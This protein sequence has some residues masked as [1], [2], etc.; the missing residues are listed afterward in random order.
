MVVLEGKPLQSQPWAEI[1]PVGPILVLTVPQVNSEIDKRKRDGRLW[2]RARE[3]NKL[4]EPAAL[5]VKPVQIVAGPPAVDIGI[6]KTSKVDW[7][8]LD[9][10]DPDDQDAKVVAQILHSVDVPADKRVFLSQDINPIT[11]ASRHGVSVRKLLDHWL[12][13]PEPSPG[14]KEAAKLKERLNILE[15]TEPKPS[16]SIT[17][18]ATS[19]LKLYTVQ[20]LQIGERSD[21]ANHIIEKHPRKQQNHSIYS[22]FDYDSQY[23]AQYDRYKNKL[24]SEH[25]ETVHTQIERLFAQIPFQLTIRNEGHVQA[26]NLVVTLRAIGGTLNEKF[27]FY[28]IYGPTPP[29]PRPPGLH[30]H[31]G[32]TFDDLIQPQVTRHEVHLPHGLSRVTK[33]EIHCADFRHGREWQ[34]DGVAIIDSRAGSPFKIVATASASNLKGSETS[35]FELS[36]FTES[37]KADDLI[38]M[39]AGGL[40]VHFP[41]F[42]ELQKAIERGDHEWYERPNTLDDD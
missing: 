38:A 29:H 7:T 26:E 41:M 27:A 1:D 23:D 15:A 28:P 40:K 37:A 34:F 22:S 24:V 21:F 3:F 42:D 9:D 19:P 31:V 18:N 33:G 13:D 16:V 10:L 11:I 2:K 17:F 36:Y 6:A 35:A 39:P 32:R 30:P 14:D 25:T 8:E 4:I 20:P 5:A 12:L